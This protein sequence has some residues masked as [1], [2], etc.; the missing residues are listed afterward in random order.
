MDGNQIFLV[1]R[2]KYPDPVWSMTRGYLAR[3]ARP[4]SVRLNMDGFTSEGIMIMMAYRD[5]GMTIEHYSPVWKS[6]EGEGPERWPRLRYPLTTFNYSLVGQQGPE[7]LVSLTR[8]IVQERLHLLE[9]K[10]K[11]SFESPHFVIARKR[12]QSLRIRINEEDH[13][14]RDFEPANRRSF[15]DEI[16]H[17]GVIRKH[18]DVNWKSYVADQK[19]QKKRYWEDHQEIPE[20]YYGGMAPIA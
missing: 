1:P 16:K 11:V 20:D 4:T 8:Q 6:L 18:V 9:I 19:R 12:Y 14:M 3:G 10:C 17:L 15:R 13:F 2:K 5:L 7:Q